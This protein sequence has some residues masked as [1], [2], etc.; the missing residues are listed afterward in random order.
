MFA[1]QISTA[2]VIRSATEADW[3]AISLA[4]VFY[5]SCYPVTALGLLLLIRSRN[6][7]RD[8]ASLIDSLIVTIGLGLLSWIVL[9]APLA[10]PPG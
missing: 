6:P 4:D 1:S 2:L 7:G 8:W 10:P 9:I 3:P 5:L